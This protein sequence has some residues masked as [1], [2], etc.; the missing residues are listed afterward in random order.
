MKLF[1]VSQVMMLPVSLAWGPAGHAIIAGL[2][3]PLLSPQGL[4]FI[5][6]HS[7]DGYELDKSINWPDSDDANTR[8]PGSD[9]WHYSFTPYRACD[10]F[11]FDRDC[12]GGECVVTGIARAAEIISDP[13]VSENIR[14]DY[15]NFFLHF[16]GDIHQPLHTG[17]RKD[18]GGL[19][20]KLLFP[21]D[22]TLH[23][24]WDSEIISRMIWINMNSIRVSSL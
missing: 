14:K 1:F 12:V 2:M 19:D 24:V 5:I 18:H 3:K 16:M 23:D 8:Y 10:T 21:Q 4:R 13:S 11:S 20:I 6:T 9:K 22:A 7:G 17:F 15:M